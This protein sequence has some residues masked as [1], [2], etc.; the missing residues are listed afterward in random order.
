MC[1]FRLWTQVAPSF[2][3]KVIPTHIP[4]T[5]S[6]ALPSS[7]VSSATGNHVS[8]IVADLTGKEMHHSI[9]SGKTLKY[10]WG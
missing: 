2:T 3:G 6:G 5:A 7:K 1:V 10:Y 9:S 4:T 8:N